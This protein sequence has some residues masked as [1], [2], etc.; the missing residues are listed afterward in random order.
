MTPP[1]LR[2]GVLFWKGA[3]PMA[4]TWKET[5]RSWC[6]AARGAANMAKFRKPFF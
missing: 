2:L 6:M 5:H 3:V 4:D 1:A